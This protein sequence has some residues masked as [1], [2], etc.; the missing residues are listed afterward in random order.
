M[1]NNGSYNLSFPQN[2]I[3]TVNKN[4]DSRMNV[5]KSIMQ[6]FSR[7]A[8]VFAVCLLTLTPAF[9]LT[10]ESHVLSPDNSSNNSFEPSAVFKKCW[11]DYDVTDGGRK[12]MRIHVSFDVTCL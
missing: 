1:N 2:A 8:L 6:K 9:A 3:D 5:T 12:G 10:N 4:G 11:I 7:I